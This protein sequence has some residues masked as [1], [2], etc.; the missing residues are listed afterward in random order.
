MTNFLKK[1]QYIG[2]YVSAWIFRALKS[3][4]DGK[5][6]GHVIVFEHIAH[7]SLV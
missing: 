2:V 6:W 4:K 1:K 7:D 5:Y 3:E